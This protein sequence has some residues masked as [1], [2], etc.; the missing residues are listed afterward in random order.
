[1]KRIRLLL[2]VAAVICT[3]AMQAQKKQNLR[4]LFVGGT[5]DFNTIG[6]TTK[7]DSAVVANSAKKRTSEWV[8]MLRRYFTEVK[9]VQ[10]RDYRQSMSDDYDVT[11][12]DGTPK[13]LRERKYIKD[14]QG[15]ITKVID[16]VYLTRDF[17]RPAVTIAEMGE[18]IGRSLG[19]KSDWYC[20][21]LLGDALGW[22]ADHPVFKGPFTVKLDTFMDDTPDMAKEI[23]VMFGKPLP[24]KTSMWKVQTKNYD[25]YPDMRIGMV[26]RPD[27]Y[28]DPDDEVISSG[29]CGKSIDAV[30]IGRHGN[31]LHWGFAAAPSLL[32][33]QAKQVFANAVVYISRFAGKP[34]ARKLDERIST[35][36]WLGAKPYTD[37]REGWIAN[38]QAN[39]KFNEM[40][41]SI[42]FVAKA[43]QAKGQKLSDMEAIYINFNVQKNPTFEQY[44]RDR[45]P[46]LYK[47]FGTNTNLYVKYYEYNRPYFYAD[48]YNLKI[49]EDARELGIGNDDKRLLDTCISLL[50]QGKDTTRAR[51]ILQQYTL[52]RFEKPEQ[53]RNW[54]D[55]Y[56]DKLFFTE[57]G[58][59]LW[60]VNEQGSNVPGNDYL[61]LD[62]EDV[63][64]APAVIGETT[65]ANPVLIA[66]KLN[67]TADGD[68]E[69]VVRIKIH[70]GYHIYANV[71]SKDPFIK[72]D[73]KIELPVGLKK[74][75][76]MILPTVKSLDSGGTTVYEGECVFRQK[77]S[78]NG[79]GKIICKVRY[80]CCDNTICLPPADKTLEFDVK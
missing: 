34:I 78:G 52:C 27:G 71:A 79:T 23:A 24:A 17:S 25:K 4:V 47:Y 54:Y 61:V 38:N 60:L 56:N 39:D 67:D 45:E 32:T 30:A 44:M 65:T 29:R 48:G 55:T 68:K 50:E 28:G 33:P 10:G 42:K 26:S 40:V 12:F 62:E 72:T 22:K 70:P 66:G 14:G 11:V 6:L 2:L 58:G 43:K 77:I 46:E 51:R 57:G 36:H 21:C 35:R 20:L 19:L 5:P 59:Y 15:R 76:S 37:S 13:P 64:P 69:L 41:D 8:S 18:R 31:F 1:M 80:Q 16:A 7:P 74:S 75:G 53:W 9:A 3:A 73:F 63:T 49:D